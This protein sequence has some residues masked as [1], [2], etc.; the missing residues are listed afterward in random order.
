MTALLRQV[1]GLLRQVAAAAAL[2]T[3]DGNRVTGLLRGIVFHLCLYGFGIF[4]ALAMIGILRM[5]PHSPLMV[6]YGEFICPFL[7]RVAG[8]KLVVNGKENMVPIKD[9]SY[10]I[11]SNHVT[12]LDVPIHM[13]SL[14]CFDISYIYS[15]K[16][17]LAIPVVGKWIA[18]IFN[19]FGWLGINPDSALSFKLC[20]DKVTKLKKQLGK[21]RVAICPEGDRS[22]QGEINEF[23]KGAFYLA[24][25][26]D[27]PIVPILMQGVSR[28]HRVRTLPVYANKVGIQI[29]PPIYPPKIKADM[30]NLSQVAISLNKQIEDLYTSIPRLNTHYDS[31]RLWQQLRAQNQ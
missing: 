11:I 29:L 23:K 21:V 3:K 26:L 20:I 10:I 28:V 13:V 6:K 7:L 14:N 22:K 31:Y 5:K 2:T 4:S 1:T 8:V 27:M 25:L 19:S 12:T 17:V 16:T 30:S 24:V 18:R 9:K 15:S